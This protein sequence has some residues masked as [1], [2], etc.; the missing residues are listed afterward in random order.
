MIKQAIQFCAAALLGFGIVA[1]CGAVGE[2][3]FGTTQEEFKV[4]DGGYGFLQ[5]YG[6]P[7]CAPTGSTG[8]QTA[9]I[10]PEIFFNGVANKKVRVGV[11]QGSNGGAQLSA[12]DQADLDAAIGRVLPRIQAVLNANSVAI[13]L[14]QWSDDLTSQEVGEVW[15]GWPAPPVD[16]GTSLSPYIFPGII[17]PSGP[18]AESPSVNGTY[19]H[20]GTG[21]NAGSDWYL[22]VGGLRLHATTTTGGFHILNTQKY[23][24]YLDHAV[25]VATLAGGLG[26]GTQVVNTGAL[27]S[28]AL[29]PSA[30]TTVLTAHEICLLKSLVNDNLVQIS[31]QT[32][33]CP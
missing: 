20:F 3:E 6:A 29:E 25:A 4:K 17:S 19:Y 12:A 18:I 16:R 11:A 33:N 26:I 27:S 14:I 21:A 13:Q 9:C 15:I 28:Q 31:F 30:K 7:S 2:E 32:N 5:N 10:V 23:H 22:D 1:G 24:D 8:P